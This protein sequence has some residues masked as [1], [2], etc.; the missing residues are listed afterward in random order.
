[1]TKAFSQGSDFVIA[2]ISLNE[3]VMLFLE[4]GPRDACASLGQVLASVIG[5]LEEEFRHLADIGEVI[6]APRHATMRGPASSRR[7]VIAVGGSPMIVVSNG[8]DESESKKEGGKGGV[9]LTVSNDVTQFMTQ[10]CLAVDPRFQLGF[11]PDFY[12]GWS[13]ICMQ[14][15]IGLH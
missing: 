10:N 15:H 1:M 14:C 6:W 3:D 5:W 11:P 12:Q 13:D 8:A 7:M 2:W 4:T 9:A